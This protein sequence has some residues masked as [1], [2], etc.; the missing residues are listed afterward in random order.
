MENSK[1]DL[2]SYEKNVRASAHVKNTGSSI[3]ASTY[4]VGDSHIGIDVPSSRQRIGE[5]PS[6]VPIDAETLAIPVV[7]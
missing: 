5:T 3:P 2:S 7:Y 1:N 4:D 6:Q